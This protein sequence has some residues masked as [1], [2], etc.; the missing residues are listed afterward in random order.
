[1]KSLKLNLTA[2]AMAATVALGSSFAAPETAQAEVAYNVGVHSKYLLRG[3]FEENNSTA[4]QGGVDW[5]NDAGWYAGWW[6]SN[7]GYSY[8]TGAGDGKTNTNG[9]ENDFYGGYSGSFGK[10]FGYDVGFIQYIYINVDD[11]DLLEATGTLTFKDF[12]VGAQ[13]LLTDGWWGNSGDIYWKAG[14]STTVAS[15]IGI[16]LDYSYYTYDSSDSSKLG[17]ATTS[18][19]GFRYFNVTASK[20]IGKT[21]AEAYVQYTFAGEDRAG[22]DYNDSM[23][24]GVTYGF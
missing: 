16:A 6:F 19:G 20:P 23:V 9:F 10:D 22:Q 7:L 11:S 17:T 21:G 3:I 2:T 15:D 18:S 4:V 5:S 12:Y 14:W 24:V 8:E 1:M 13:Y